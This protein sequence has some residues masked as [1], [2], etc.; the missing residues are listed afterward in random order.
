MALAA[1]AS[2]ATGPWENVPIRELQGVLAKLWVKD[3]PQV[4]A[5]WS[6]ILNSNDGRR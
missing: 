6:S 1:S 2:Q 5:K 3:L 4:L